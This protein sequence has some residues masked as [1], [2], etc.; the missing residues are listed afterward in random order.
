[1]KILKIKNC[2]DGGA[3]LDIEYTL[4]EAELMKKHY[5]KKKITPKLLQKAVIEGLENYLKR[6][7]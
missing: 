1:M 5:N 6:E 3:I 4:E 7:E 2:K